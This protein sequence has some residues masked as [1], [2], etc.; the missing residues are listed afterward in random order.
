VLAQAFPNV[1]GKLGAEVQQFADRA[2]NRPSG[3]LM[4]AEPLNKLLH[5]A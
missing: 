2:G 1:V 3:H 4:P 5:S